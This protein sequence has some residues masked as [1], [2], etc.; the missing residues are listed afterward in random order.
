LDDL[1][2]EV[3]MSIR[4]FTRSYDI[5]ARYD[6]TLFVAV[7]PHANLDNALEYGKKIMSDIDASTFSDPNFPTK[8]SV[9]VS[10]VTVHKGSEAITADEVF[11]EAMRTLLTA[12][13]QPRDERIMGRDLRQ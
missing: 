11:G 2:A 7:L 3:P 9:S 6:G 4:E 1:L 12:K 5:L 8:T 13:S 10:A